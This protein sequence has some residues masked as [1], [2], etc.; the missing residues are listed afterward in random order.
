M[1]FARGV[2]GPTLLIVAVLL[3]VEAATWQERTPS[4]EGPPRRVAVAAASSTTNVLTEIAEIYEKQHGE[5]IQLNFASASTLARQIEAGSPAD[6]FLSANPLWMDYLE[7]PGRIQVSTR[8]DLLANRLVLIVPKGSRF[9][10]EMSATFD[11]AG[12]FAG[13][14]AVGDPEHVP[15]GIYGRQALEHF[16]WHAALA[17]RIVAC[18]NV[19]MALAMV[20]LK[21]AAAGIVY[22]TDAA[23]SE[24][25]E[26]LAEF[27][28]AAHEPIRYPVALCR[29]ASPAAAG[30]LHYLCGPEAG[31]VF[32]RH[33]F[34]PLA[35]SRSPGG[36]DRE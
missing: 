14:L 32:R 22:A 5:R 19:R 30:F 1:R 13:R 20:E 24:K 8:R 33:G 35:D 23:V 16:G 15:A 11:L 18:Q 21:E 7:K 4:A 6:V 34:V 10:V 36:I 25:V 12:A 2:L 31:E 29:D 3:G 17:P 28:E 9:P 27:P 26:V